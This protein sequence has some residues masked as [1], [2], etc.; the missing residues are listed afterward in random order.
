[1]GF[2]AIDDG[3]GHMEA[4]FFAEVYERDRNKLEKDRLVILEGEVQKDEFT[5]GYK[6]VAQRALTIEEARSRF[7]DG[8]RMHLRDADM[9][10]DTAGRLKQALAPHVSGNGGC[11]VSICYTSRGA[12]GWVRLGPA[13]SV[14]G[15]DDLLSQLQA[16]FGTESVAFHYSANRSA[17]S[18]RH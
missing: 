14:R 4:S 9:A 3:S 8:L 13:W 12:E 15:S 2:A 16:E 5:D 11:P 10:P 6:L 17:I 7:S 1:M 18:R